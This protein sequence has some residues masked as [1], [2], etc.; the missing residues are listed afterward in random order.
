MTESYWRGGGGEKGE[1]KEEVEENIQNTVKEMFN[2]GST[3]D[4]TFSPSQ[5]DTKV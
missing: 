4:V 1:I 5:Q 3:K 2:G